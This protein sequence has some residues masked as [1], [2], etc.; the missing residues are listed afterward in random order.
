MQEERTMPEPKRSLFATPHE[1]LA[2]VTVWNRERKWGFT[3]EDLARV[4]GGPPPKARDG[5]LVAD[6]LT[7]WLGP[8]RDASG[9]I[10]TFRELKAVA[11][12]RFPAQWSWEG[13]DA[14]DPDTLRPAH[15]VRQGR[16][17][18][19]RTIDLGAN[20]DVAPASVPRSDGY[21]G[22]SLLAAAALHPNWMASMD[23]ANVPY[24]WLAGLDVNMPGAK[25]PWSSKP[26]LGFSQPFRQIHLHALDAAMKHRS[27][28]IPI[29]LNDC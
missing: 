12:D 27:W 18:A 1:Q 15:R 8:S 7:V 17:L 26:R 6:V 16:R 22:L 3:A 21:P 2:A 4:V 10:R 19:W 23:G 29:F 24:V 9:L 14:A 28:A 5:R 20:R 11:F 25:V 13:Y